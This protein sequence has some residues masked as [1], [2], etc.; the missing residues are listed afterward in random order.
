ME[1]VKLQGQQA[2]SEGSARQRVEEQQR[3]V[4]SLRQEIHCEQRRAERELE[5]EQAHLRQQHAESKWTV[6]STMDRC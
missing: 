3:Y 4:E 6:T 5:R 1:D 2:A